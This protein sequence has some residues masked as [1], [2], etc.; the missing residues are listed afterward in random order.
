MKRQLCPFLLCFEFDIGLLCLSQG[1]C[2]ITLLNIYHNT[3]KI[4]CRFGWESGLC[5][6]I[7]TVFALKQP[8]STFFKF[9]F[10]GY[11]LNFT[12]V[13]HC[14]YHG[15]IPPPSR[16]IVGKNQS[17]RSKTI[18]KSNR[19]VSPKVKRG[20]LYCLHFSTCFQAEIF[21]R[22]YRKLPRLTKSQVV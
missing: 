4:L 13:F 10:I 15:G 18:V 17:T 5:F 20:P 9:F 21:F 16:G 6:P 11:S 14:P 3:S 7:F 2:T 12:V 19:W 8:F 1:N 22:G